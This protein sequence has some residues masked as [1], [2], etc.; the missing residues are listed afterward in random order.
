M[1]VEDLTASPSHVWAVLFSTETGDFAI[2]GSPIGKD[3]WTTDPL[4]LPLGAGPVS[5]FQVVLKGAS[6]WIVDND[7]GV[8]AGATLSN[9]SWAAW[10]PP[11]SAGSGYGDAELAAVNE[12]DLTAFCPPSPIF[13]T[14]PPPALFTSTNGGQTFQK[15]AATPP[16]SAAGLAATS[17]GTLLCY[18]ERGIAGSFNTGQ[19]WV[20]A[21]KLKRTLSPVPNAGFDLISSLVGFALTPAGDLAK[22][23]NGGHVWSRL[24]FPRR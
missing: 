1:Q 23:M 13:G 16:L 24:A 8:V 6:G 18:D 12:S 17:S 10:T 11:C 9:G 15:M 4:T 20:T 14:P 7:R 19:T 22:T 21:L 2:A 3:D 5:A